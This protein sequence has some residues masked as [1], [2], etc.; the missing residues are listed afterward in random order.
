MQ[1]GD[2]VELSS[3]GKGMLWC[4]H[5]KDSTAVVVEISEEIKRIHTIKVVWIDKGI[6]WMHRSYL[7]MVAKG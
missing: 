2:L 1:V 5:Y 4:R 3:R 7:K 6:C